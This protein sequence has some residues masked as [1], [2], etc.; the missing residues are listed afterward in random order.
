MVLISLSGAATT[1]AGAAR[2]AGAGTGAGT[3]AGEKAANAA[4]TTSEDVLARVEGLP[5][6]RGMLEKPLMEGYGLNVLL[7]LMQL[8]L[9]RQNAAK[10]HITVTEQDIAAERERTLNRMFK[11]ANA[12]MQD[13]LDAA[14]AKKNNAAAD[15]I[16]EQIRHDNAEGLVAYLQNQRVGESEF[17][18]LVETLAYLRKTAE[19]MLV[20]K[21][22]DDQ[23]KEAFG[24][25]Y[26]E[27]VKCRHIQLTNL[28]E[29]QEAKR[30]LAAGEPFGKVATEMSRNPSTGPL[31]GEMRPFS[32]QMTS[33]PQQFRDT[34][35]KLQEGEVSD[36]VEAEGAYH[37]ILLEKRIPPKAV[38]FEDVKQSLRAELQDRA[39][40]ATVEQLH[41]DLAAQTLKGLKIDDPLL[42]RQFQ[43]RQNRN[44]AEIHGR[45][46]AL[47]QMKREEQRDAA[48]SK[49][50]PGLSPAPPSS[51]GPAPRAP[52]APTPVAP[53][54]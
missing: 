44:S 42:E 10:A 20:G 27:K 17:N 40:D 16:R 12:K 29:V 30:R 14:L 37:L 13:K 7:N 50:G 52:A 51:T 22:S 19:P 46:D 28:Q 54:P 11:D 25:L 35:F 6:T 26:G 9:A 48:E 45:Q 21:I 18:I 33:V 23:L 32:M 5:I 4:V 8:K 36:P 15:K 49:T 43:D 47:K 41:R 53:T 3:G 31:G 38:K 1:Q 34:A 2:A 39:L 24:A